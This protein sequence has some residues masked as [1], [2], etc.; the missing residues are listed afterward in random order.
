MKSIYRLFLLTLMLQVSV[1]CSGWWGER[2]PAGLPG[3]RIAILPG[4]PP[5]LTSK[6][7]QPVTDIP[8]PHRNASWPQAGGFA[9]HAMH[10]LAAPSSSLTEIWSR[11][12][13]GGSNQ[14]RQLLGSPVI[15][16]KRIYTIT[17]DAVVTELDALTGK[18][19]WSKE[20]RP[21][22]GTR[23]EG[24]LGGGL[25]VSGDLLFATT[26]TGLVV[27]MKR[28]NGDVIWKKNIGSPIRSG[29]TIYDG[30]VIVSG[31]TNETH[32]FDLNNGTK[33][34]QHFGMVES[35]IFM[36]ASSP[37]AGSSTV[38]ISHS[39]GELVALGSQNGNQLWIESMVAAKKASPISNISHS[40][41]HPIIDRNLV[42]A[43]SNSGRTIASDLISGA[44]VWET[45][46]GSSQSPW[47]AG[48]H[49]FLVTTNRQLVC[50]ER[51][52]GKLAW[53]TELKSFENSRNKEKAIE[54]TGPVLAG[55]RILLAGSNGEVWSASPF[56]GELLGKIRLSNAVYISPVV[57]DG[58]VYIL[59]DNARLYA[60][61]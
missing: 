34:W 24:T 49:I 42:F 26:G 36:G 3:N 18:K 61:R 33:R 12:L 27:C 54:W 7:D 4:Q 51:R 43:S 45:N 53:A 13:G 23:F 58:I 52:T 5:L 14:Y 44:R 2:E 30:Q 31:I 8:R 16:K 56:S 10:H 19:I 35:A 6:G 1:G 21:V 55:D 38:V 57:A 25:A 9:H 46:F 28:N 20:L 48:K 37:A 47:V 32:S 60:F 17:A 50:I 40:R 11:A 39:S 15:I 41:G 29:P 59:T 22:M